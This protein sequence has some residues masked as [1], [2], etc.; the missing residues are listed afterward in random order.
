MFNKLFA[1]LMQGS[2]VGSGPGAGLGV[3]RSRRFV[4]SRIPNNTGSRSRIF[5]P[6]PDV[7]FDHFLHH[8]PKFGIPLEMVQFLLKLMLKQISCGVTR[9][10]LI[11]TFK[12]HSLCVK[13][14]ESEILEKSTSGIGV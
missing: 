14:S 10:S 1:A 9:F 5:C 2:E 4:R 8:I 11:L 13:E 6:T 12:F 7:Q 3:A